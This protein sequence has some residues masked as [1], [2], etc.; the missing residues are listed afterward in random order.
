MTMFGGGA[1]TRAARPI[2]RGAQFCPERGTERRSNRPDH[3][4]D[5][6]LASVRSWPRLCENSIFE[7][8]LEESTLQNALE[9]TIV[10]RGDVLVPI[11]TML[12][13]VFTQPRPVSA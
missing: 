10:V 4:I 2:P 1:I 9:L 3:P 8:S 12:V 5:K 11:K 13:G 7:S 6:P